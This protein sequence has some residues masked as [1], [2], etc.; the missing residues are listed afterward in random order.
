MMKI[1]A[2]L[3][4]FILA[5]L[6][7]AQDSTPNAFYQDNVVVVFDASGSMEWEFKGGGTG[8]DRITVAR[9]SLKAVLQQIPSTTNVGILVF[10][11]FGGWE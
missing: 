3:I 4:A 10:G 11:I 9:R 2:T 1:I 7:M 5:P 8:E 6:C